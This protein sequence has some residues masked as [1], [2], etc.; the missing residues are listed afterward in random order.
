VTPRFR[1]AYPCP[2]KRDRQRN[3]QIFKKFKQFLK[4]QIMYQGS[5]LF[6]LWS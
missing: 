4:E 3:M 1:I 2:N 5:T 6:K